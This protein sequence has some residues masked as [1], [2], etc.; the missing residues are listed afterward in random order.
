MTPLRHAAA[1]SLL[2]APLVSVHAQG[3]PAKPIRVIVPYAAGGNMEHWRPTLVKVSQILGVS[4]VME[5]RPGAGGNVGSD[6]VAKSV[7][8]GYTIV[9]GTMGTHAINPGVYASMPYD[10]VRDFTPVGMIA[11]M[12]NVVAVNPASPARSVQE[13][14][15]F[16]KANPGKLN[17]ASPGNG[18]SA[19]VTGE[20][21]KQVTGISMQHVPYK[22]SAPAIMDLL[23]GRVDIVF[24]NIPLP[25][26]HIKS[27]KLRALAVTAAR[28]SPNLPEAPT[29]A[30]AGVPGF[31]V[32][33]WYAIYGPAGLPP[34]V[35]A[36]LNGAFNEALRLPEIRDQLTAQGWT[37]A[38]GTPEQLGAYTQEEIRRWGKVTKSANIRVE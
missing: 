34:Q 19:H 26:P 2:L 31:D 23:G 4:L 9:I 11:T 16:A 8:D 6:H 13:F 10:A 15:D 35:T 25:L 29:L 12:T 21:F 38:T 17:F 28:R 24:D 18:S 36:T 20:L 22:G 30:E 14:I 7:P 27:G 33:S 3:Y 1:L 32:S 37:V 5:N